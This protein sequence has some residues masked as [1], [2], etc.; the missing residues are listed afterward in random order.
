MLI[1]KNIRETLIFGNECSSF[2][3]SGEVPLAHL[4]VFNLDQRIELTNLLS[5]EIDALRRLKL[6][7]TPDQLNQLIPEVFGPTPV[8][9]SRR[10][11]K[12]HVWIFI[13]NRTF[14]R[15]TNNWPPEPPSSTASTKKS[16]S[17]DSNEQ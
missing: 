15:N 16:R 14:M 12:D 3:G 17:E 7:L 9:F 1:L 2:P 8:A 10:V 4:L 11:P 6:T 13:G 5:K